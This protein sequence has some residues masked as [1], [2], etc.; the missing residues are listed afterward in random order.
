[1]T[2]SFVEVVCEVRLEHAPLS[3]NTQTAQSTH[4][5][6]VATARVQPVQIKGDRAFRTTFRAVGTEL[7]N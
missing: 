4:L 5:A 7:A 1:M 6:P 2:A 3:G